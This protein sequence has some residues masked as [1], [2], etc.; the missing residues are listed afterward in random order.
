MVSP[1]L[2]RGRLPPSATLEPVPTRINL[3]RHKSR[4]GKQQSQISMGGVNKESTPTW[5]MKS[6]LFYVTNSVTDFRLC[7]SV[8]TRLGDASSSPERRQR[9]RDTHTTAN[10]LRETHTNSAPPPPPPPSR[11]NSSPFN[12]L[13]I[14]TPTLLPRP[15][16]LGHS[17]HTS[18]HSSPAAASLAM[19]AQHSPKA[20]HYR[21]S[22]GAALVRGAWADANPGTEPNG[23]PLSWAELI[24]KWAKHTGGSE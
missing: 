9:L 16:T 19:S 10:A 6:L 20:A 24:R 18:H 7:G 2:Y 12:T 3:A 22:L 17:H 11:P 23:N 4:A 1:I 8:V 5:L 15:T 13:P 21:A 14:D